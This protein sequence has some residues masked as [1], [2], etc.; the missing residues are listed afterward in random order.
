MAIAEAKHPDAPRGHTPVI[1]PRRGLPNGRALVGALL[2]TLA[3][4]GSFAVATAGN[5]GP[6][7]EYLVLDSPIEAGDPVML[8]AVSLEPM[9]LSPTLIASA[10]TTTDGLEG[11]TAL[12]D[13][14]AGELLAT[15]DL[16]AAPTIDG[17]AIFEVHELTFAVPLE[18]TPPG[19]RRGDRVTILGTTADATAVAVEDALVLTIDTRTDQIGSSGSGVLTLAIDDALSVMTIA[20]VTQTTDITVVRS[21]RALA[22]H[23]PEVVTGGEATP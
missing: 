21:T 5:D 3:A 10:L 16:I 11:A 20:H 22:D 8:S 12:R 18:R 9:E 23:Y 6:G 17:R 7:T 13:L 2:V 15:D 19:L 4:V 14:R 1:T